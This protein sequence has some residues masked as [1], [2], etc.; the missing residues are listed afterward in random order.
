MAEFDG[1]S[2]PDEK[3]TALLGLD[4]DSVALGSKPSGGG[5]AG[6]AELGRRM[7][8]GVVGTTEVDPRGGKMGEGAS[9]LDV[10]A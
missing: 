4:F 10:D 9:T 1:V 3:R 2:I 5:G 6:D 7:A 8:A